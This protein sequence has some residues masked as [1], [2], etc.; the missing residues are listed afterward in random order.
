VEGSRSQKRRTH[1]NQGR[2]KDIHL[3][4]ETK[5]GELYL[6]FNRKFMIH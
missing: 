3:S 1:W 2:I 6:I 4:K 5:L